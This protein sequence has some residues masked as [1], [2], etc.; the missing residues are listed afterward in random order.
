VTIGGSNGQGCADMSGAFM[1][2]AVALA[3]PLPD[4]SDTTQGGDPVVGEVRNEITGGFFFSAV[5]Q[6][7]DVTVQLPP[8]VKPAL[9]GLRAG[10][11]SFTGRKT[12]LREVLD[13]FA[14]A[15]DGVPEQGAGGR[16]RVAAVAGMAGVGKTELA[17]QAARAAR[18]NGWFPGGVLFIDLFGYDPAR[19]L[20]PAQALDG[21]LRALGIPGEHIPVLEQDRARLYASVLAAYAEEGRPILVVIDNS[22]A[23]GQV[24]PLLPA[25]EATGVIVTSRHTLGMLGGRLLD[26]NVLSRDDAVELLRRALDVARPGDTRVS[27]HP[28]GAA[29]VASL[30]GDLPLALQVIAALLAEDQARSLGGMAADLAVA[31]SRLEEL[32]YEDIAVRAAFDLSYQCLDSRHACLFRLLPVSPGPDISVDAIA[33]LAGSDKPAAR[34]SLEALARA[35]LIERG[36]SYGRWQMHDLLRLYAG[37]QGSAHGREDSREQARDRLLGYYLDMATAANHHLLASPDKAAP[38]FADRDSALAWFD[39]ERPNLIAAVDM[40]AA[41][42]R[43]EIAQ[44]LPFRLGAYLDRRRRFDDWLAVTA[45]SVDAA[46]LRGDRRRE[47]DALNNLGIALRNARRFHDA[48][49]AHQDAADI[50][51]ETGHRHG[52]ASALNNLGIALQEVRRFDDAVTAHQDAADIHRETGHRHS[53]ASALNNLGIA[54]RQVRRFGEAITACRSAVA[55]YQETGDRHSEGRALNSLGCAFRA[56]GRS[57]EAIIMHREDL[58]IC[59]QSGD[60]HGEA[61]ALNNLGLALLDAGRF[62]E[63]ITACQDAVAFY[64]ETGDQHSEI[65]ALNNLQTARDAQQAH[66]APNGIHAPSRDSSK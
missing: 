55:F 30:C 51:R 58:G 22:S 57:D 46:R 50:Y 25:D 10:S 36:G 45:V 14:P 53:E 17:V 23:A 44:E 26:L 56:A 43:D 47:G 49:I 33:V 28:G 39:T 54:L 4:V 37:K 7:R 61:E 32:Q 1:I 8:E 9:A 27:D 52:E 65:Q 11:S 20:E 48:V 66:E 35:H 6:G 12:D 5:I 31:A 15:S 2:L 40:A 3:R 34:H 38:E 21:L 13:I 16:V 62:G 59:R 42:S 64:Q 18:R 29:Q 60:R 63:A 41:T 24:R 19:R